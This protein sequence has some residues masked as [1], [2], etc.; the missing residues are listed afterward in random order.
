MLKFVKD[1]ENLLMSDNDSYQE[2]ILFW[3]VI[4]DIKI[5]ASTYEWKVGIKEEDREDEII[6]QQAIR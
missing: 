2:D 3:K 1:F 5:Q 4:L 6:Y